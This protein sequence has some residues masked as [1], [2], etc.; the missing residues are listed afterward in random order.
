MKTTTYNYKKATIQD[1][2]ELVRTRIIV[3]RVANKLSVDVDMSLVEAE[4]YE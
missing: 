1:I 4:S 2:D 3:L